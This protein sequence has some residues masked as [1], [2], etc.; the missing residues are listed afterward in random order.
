[1]NLYIYF[2]NKYSW[3][4]KNSTSDSAVIETIDKNDDKDNV[5]ENKN[6]VKNGNVF[7]KNKKIEV[8]SSNSAEKIIIEH[9]EYG[10]EI[11]WTS[12][13]ET[14]GYF[15]YTIIEY[16]KDGNEFKWTDYDDSDNVYGITYLKYDNQGR[17]IQELDENGNVRMQCIYNE[18]ET[19]TQIW[20]PDDVSV[21]EYVYDEHGNVIKET[22]YKNDQ[23]DY[24][25]INEYD[26][27]NVLQKRTSYD[28]NNNVRF[29][30]THKVIE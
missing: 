9:D 17:K 25:D 5:S 2:S 10:R 30:E 21:S 29:V 3:S 20:L 1:M 16:D 15:Y 13:N 27:N 14:D 19:V 12:Y 4:E 8:V 24:Y 7:L 11:K 6:V 23:I 26:K 18:D 28:S 22:V